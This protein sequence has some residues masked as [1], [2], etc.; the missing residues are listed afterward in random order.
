MSLHEL[1]YIWVCR[2]DCTTD[3]LLSHHFSEE[4]AN[5]KVTDYEPEERALPPTIL[6]PRKNLFER[7]FCHS[8]NGWAGNNPK[9]LS[10]NSMSQKISCYVGV[11]N[12]SDVFSCTFRIPNNNFKAS[13]AQ[14][15]DWKVFVHLHFVSSWPNLLRWQV[16]L[17]GAVS[18]D[19][20]LNSLISI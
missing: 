8:N 3:W 11:H 19:N 14:R 2:T 16:C 20:C 13:M 12:S 9:L 6:Q 15:W 18:E 4:Y 1:K 7:E 5:R 17:L 10:N